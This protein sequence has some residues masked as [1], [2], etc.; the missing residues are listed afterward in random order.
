MLDLAE[1][2]LERAAGAARGLDHH[3]EEG[4][5]KHDILEPSCFGAGMTIASC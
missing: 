4:G 1:V 5:A 2:A 3:V